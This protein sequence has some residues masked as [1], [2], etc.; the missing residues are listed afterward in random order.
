[1]V[2]VGPVNEF[3]EQNLSLAIFVNLPPL[4]FRLT[5]VNAPLLEC[6]CSCEELF[7]V[8]SL[9]F[10]CVHFVKSQKEFVILPQVLQHVPKLGSFGDIVV[11]AR[12]L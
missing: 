9:V 1:M 2:L 11:S 5:H 6:G 10:S 3:A 4:I 8:N 7:F 12:S